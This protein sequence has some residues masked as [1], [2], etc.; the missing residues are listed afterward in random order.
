[1]KLGKKYSFK[2]IPNTPAINPR[3]VSIDAF[4]NPLKVTLSEQALRIDRLQAEL[5]AVRRLLGIIR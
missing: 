4:R 3:P 5:D 1:M 2:Q